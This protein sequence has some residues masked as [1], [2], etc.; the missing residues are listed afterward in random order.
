MLSKR[1]SGAAW[2]DD[3]LLLCDDPMPPAKAVA[4]AQAGGLRARTT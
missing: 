3:A 2:G 4:S 1:K